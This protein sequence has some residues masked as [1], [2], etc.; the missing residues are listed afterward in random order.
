MQIVNLL[1]D[2]AN[3]PRLKSL[4]NDFFLQVELSFEMW[5]RK[6]SV[7]F[8]CNTLRAIVEVFFQIFFCYLFLLDISLI[9]SL[10]L[11]ILSKKFSIFSWINATVGAYWKHSLSFLLM[12]CIVE[13]LFIIK[14]GE[15]MNLYM[16]QHVK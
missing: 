11:V 2:N 10:I 12:G 15:S 6:N 14:S 16:I 1:Q 7:S 4:K 8:S 5:G 3:F 13:F 9:N